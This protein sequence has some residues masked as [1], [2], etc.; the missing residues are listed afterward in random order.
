MV[1]LQNR[2]L[3]V[4][5]LERRHRGR[6]KT[7]ILPP[8]NADELQQ[9]YLKAAPRLY[10]IALGMLH[11]AAAAEDVAQDTFVGIWQRR[12]RFETLNAESAMAYFAQA[13]RH[14]CLNRLR[15]EAPLSLD[16]DTHRSAG[17]NEPAAGA[18]PEEL[19][20]GREALDRL[21]AAVEHLPAKQARAFS[22][23]HFEGLDATQIATQ[24]NET[25]A[26][27]RLLLSRARQTLKQQ[28]A[29]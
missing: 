9:T 24:M 2:T 13:V 19:L 28:I 17:F 23:F 5:R 1:L 15:R 22:L 6:A 20:T 4:I 27:V 10:A 25:E 26:Y 11:E 21:Y 7:I 8:M 14:Q 16:D 18:N 3:C 29:L 12:E